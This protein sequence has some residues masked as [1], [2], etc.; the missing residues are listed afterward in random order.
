MGQYSTGKSKNP[1]QNADHFGF[2]GKI[3]E[4]AWPKLSI[5]PAQVDLL[6][7]LGKFFKPTK[8][9]F[10]FLVLHLTLLSVSGCA[11]YHKAV[12]SIEPLLGQYVVDFEAEALWHNKP[13]IV[14]DLVVKFG[15]MV[16][17]D[18]V[19]Y[20]WQPAN[21][22]PVVVIDA[23]YWQTISAAEQ[24]ILMFHE[25]GHCVLHRG[26]NNA[27]DSNH[28]PSS[29]MYWQLFDGSYYETNRESYLH[30]LF[31]HAKLY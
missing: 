29:I 12:L 13:L 22:T 16:D 30:E 28:M 24:E 27:L 4:T 15:P 2:L 23:A 19:G 17:H 9:V 25:L 11:T 3:I 1:G 14:E 6:V 18:S 26:H 20:C 10:A 21:G 5:W 7:F 8:R 31:G